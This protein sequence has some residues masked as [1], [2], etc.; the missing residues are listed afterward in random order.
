M[1][2]ILATLTTA[3]AVWLL[4]GPNTPTTRLSHLL[5]PTHPPN[6]RPLL[7]RL[8]RPRPARRQ[9]A[10]RAASIDLC[11]GL[12]AELSA[13]LTPAEALT[14]AAATV[15]FPTPEPARLL[16]AAARDGGD[17]PKALSTFGFHHLAACWTVSTT[18]GAG[19][20]PLVDRVAQSLRADQAHRQDVAAQLA[21]PRA[22]A[23]M[24]AVLP[25]LGLLMAAALDMNPLGFL[26]GGL[27]GL[28]CLTAGLA[29][30][31]AGLWWTHRMA[32]R[33]ES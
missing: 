29:L 15:D 2:T 11:Q 10:W 1:T 5:A 26:F 12:S 24:L 7:H 28:S 22:T 6:W 17:I 21:G 9:A 25:A 31:A 4:T 3:I 18:V 30:D 33:A 23:R 19:L 16:A 13:G 14:R 32:V 27:P 8:T 20:S